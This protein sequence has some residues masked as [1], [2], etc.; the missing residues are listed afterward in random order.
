MV[1]VKNLANLFLWIDTSVPQYDPNK[2]SHWE[3]PFS[4][5]LIT[6]DW[7]IARSGIYFNLNHLKGLPQNTVFKAEAE[8]EY[9]SAIL[10]I[11]YGYQVISY[12]WW[13]S[14]WKQLIRILAV[15]NCAS[16]GC[17]SFNTW[18]LFLWKQ[19]YQNNEPR[20][21]KIGNAIYPSA[22]EQYTIH[23]N[24]PR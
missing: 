23:K 11:I 22:Q 21:L 3:Y 6:M 12:M 16:Q 17:S 13:K 14:Y 24:P 8:C 5:I 18:C 1:V 10:S 20:N 19:L 7:K 2:R 4:R 9:S 15:S